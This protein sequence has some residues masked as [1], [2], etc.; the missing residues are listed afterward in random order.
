ME[1]KRDGVV[2]YRINCH[3]EQEHEASYGM[4][5]QG[6]QQQYQEPLYSGM[7]TAD[8][9]IMGVPISQ[10]LPHG[11]QHMPPPP[12]PQPQQQ[13]QQ[14]QQM[15]P[16]QAPPPQD[17]ARAQGANAGK[18]NVQ[19]ELQ[20]RQ[21]WAVGSVIE[22]YSSSASKWYIASV[23]KVG[24]KGAPLTLTVQ[25]IG[26]NGQIM[27]KSMPRSDMQLAPF[28]RN[29]RQMPPGFQKVESA[30]RPGEFS[31]QD[32]N[33][34]TKY[35]TKEFAWQC[36]YQKV[37][38]C[39]QAQQLLAQQHG[40]PP[41]T[42]N[43]APKPAPT[44]SLAPPP[45][46]VGGSLSPDLYAGASGPDPILAKTWK[47]QQEA[48]MQY[49][50]P[51]TTGP[52]N[53]GSICNKVTGGVQSAEEAYASYAANAGPS[54]LKSAASFMQPISTLGDLSSL[55]A[56]GNGGLQPSTPFPGYGQSFA[57]GQNAGYE[58]YLASQ[59]LA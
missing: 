9:P 37:L 11:N 17:S 55:P 29:T 43:E 57:V 3:M 39:E 54:N 21:S 22:V 30:S 18:M 56:S 27:Q 52:L 35:Q 41:S 58:S 50:Q 42:P 40:A 19:D 23:V 31:Y 59:G 32:T 16:H 45:S 14:Q 28:G 2:Q 10:Q 33:T 38:K 44:M 49:N 53:G 5:Q 48:P 46:K 36:Y 26:D 24:A 47:D 12:P 15:P 13:Q 1:E 20:M 7:V 4:H 34:M 51:V 8:E 6:Q 25:F